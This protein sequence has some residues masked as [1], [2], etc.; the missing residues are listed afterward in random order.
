MAQEIEQEFGLAASRAEM[1]IGNPDAAV[2]GDR[3]VETH[4]GGTRKEFMA[5]GVMRYPASS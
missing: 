5:I 1:D 2:L 4:D 3:R